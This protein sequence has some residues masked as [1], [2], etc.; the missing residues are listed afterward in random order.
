MNQNLS[1]NI[2]LEN[3]KKTIN[4]KIRQIIT[5]YNHSLLKTHIK[6]NQKQIKN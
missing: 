4:K 6:Y 3:N 5:K 2:I 1:N